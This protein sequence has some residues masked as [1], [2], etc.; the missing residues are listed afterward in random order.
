VKKGK[1]TEMQMD[2]SGDIEEHRSR[3]DEVEKKSKGTGKEV[4]TPGA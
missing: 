4:E 3:N 1:D 2:V